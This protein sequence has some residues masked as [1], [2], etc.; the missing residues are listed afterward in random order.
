MRRSDDPI[1]KELDRALASKNIFGARAI[2][3][4]DALKKANAMPSWAIPMVAEIVTGWESEHAAA[5]AA[6]ATIRAAQERVA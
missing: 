5:V 3:L 1:Y 2:G 6:L 4:L